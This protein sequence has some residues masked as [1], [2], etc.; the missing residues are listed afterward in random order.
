MKKKQFKSKANRVPISYYTSKKMLKIK[1]L[2]FFERQMNKNIC[3]SS[4]SSVQTSIIGKSEVQLLGFI[5]SS[6]LSPSHQ[7]KSFIQ[8][9]VRVPLFLF[10]FP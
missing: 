2:P 8:D 9:R 5:E 3:M 6:S 1:N 7:L 10:S 4:Y